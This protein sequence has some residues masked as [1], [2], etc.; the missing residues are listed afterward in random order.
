MTAC[1][2]ETA[3]QTDRDTHHIDRDARPATLGAAPGPAPDAPQGAAGREPGG[4]GGPGGTAAHRG[5]TDGAPL[6]LTADGSYAARLAVCRTTGERFP[7]R[8]TLDG[9]EPYAV[10][11]PTHQ[12]EEPDSEV[13]PLADGR[14]LIRRRVAERHALS[15]LYP[16]GPGTGELPLGF[17]ECDTLSLLPPA[18]CGVLAYALARGEQSTHIWLVHGGSLGPEHIAEVPGQCSAGSWLDR[19]GRLLAL[20]RELAGRV[21]TVVVD[22]RRGGEISPLLQITEDSDDRL[23]LAD[24]DSGLLLVRSNAPGRDRLGWGVL[25]SARPV[26]FPDC[27]DPSPDG[28]HRGAAVPSAVTLT[29]FAAQPGQTL[30][31][32]NCAVAFRL[33]PVRPVDAGRGPGAGCG[34]GA[35]FA[36]GPGASAGSGG[37]TD[38]AAGGRPGWSDGCGPGGDQGPAGGYSPDRETHRPTAGRATE[39]GRGRGDDGGSWVV[40]WRPMERRLHHVSPP[41]GWL[42]GTGLWTRNAELRLPYA[43]PQAPCGVARLRMPEPTPKPRA[44]QA[45]QPGPMPMPMPMPMAVPMPVPV[46]VPVPVPMTVPLAPMPGPMPERMPMP[47]PLHGA[48]GRESATHTRAGHE[49]AGDE[50]AAHAG[51]G[52]EPAEHAAPASARAWSADARQRTAAPCSVPPLD[53]VPP[54]RDGGVS[55]AGDA[56]AAHHQDPPPWRAGAI[57]LRGV[58]HPICRPVPLQQA[59]LTGDR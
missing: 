43:T 1:A 11:L 27:L 30:T 59:P 50:Q 10:P 4:P 31:P 45:A 12:P 48:A 18:P 13:L 41:P 54:D 56:A 23:L 16:T 40:L 8:W 47:Y 55:P 52:H 17:I 21:K 14:V 39:E 58:V 38:C 15:L 19:E 20:D 5:R 28:P 44:R 53:D 6:T 36:T 37:T 26:R 3:P 49:P 22:L 33:A 25:G 7:E 32:E 9:P 57:Q 51:A 42:A 24:P 34:A 46:P 29:P 2:I 35:S